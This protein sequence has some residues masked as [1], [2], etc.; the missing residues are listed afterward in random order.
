MFY[1]Y[2]V[3]LSGGLGSRLWPLSRSL[4]PKQLLALAG[5]QSLIQETALRTAGPGFEKT[6]NHLPRGASVS[7]GRANARHWH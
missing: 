2:P 6:I 4:F 1:I 3:I 5:E 7:G